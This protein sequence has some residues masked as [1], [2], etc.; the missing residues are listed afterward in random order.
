MRPFVSCVEFLDTKGLEN[1]NADCEKFCVE[2]FEC[3]DEPRTQRS[4]MEHRQ[5]KIQ[6][7]GER[8]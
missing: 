6:T 8:P 3:K 7:T 4:F 1:R 2:N 5:V